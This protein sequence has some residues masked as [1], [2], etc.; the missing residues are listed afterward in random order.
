MKQ[1][2]IGELKL[3]DEG[4]LVFSLIDAGESEW[5]TK[6]TLKTNS[7]TI[8]I[9]GIVFSVDSII[10]FLKECQNRSQYVFG[11]QQGIGEAE[12]KDWIEQRKLE[13]T[14]YRSENPVP[15]LRDAKFFVGEK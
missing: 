4:K 2:K 13:E 8:D 11:Q 1:I 5:Y 7:V 3:M 15:P 14:A 6:L 10:E 9:P 12:M